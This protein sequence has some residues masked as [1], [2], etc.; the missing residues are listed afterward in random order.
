[1]KLGISS[2]PKEDSVLSSLQLENQLLLEA[3]NDSEKLKE[4]FEEAKIGENLQTRI[5]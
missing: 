3:I 2:Q 4:D 1:L 5:N